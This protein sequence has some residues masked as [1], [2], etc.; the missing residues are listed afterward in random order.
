V[1]ATWAGWN[2]KQGG[3]GAYIPFDRHGQPV[4]IT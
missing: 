3:I 2:I 1:A 4:E